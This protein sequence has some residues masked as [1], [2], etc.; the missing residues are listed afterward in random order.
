M[1][2]AVHLTIAAVP[3]TLNLP[4][5]SQAKRIL[6]CFNT[7]LAEFELTLDGQ[8]ITGKN[9][10]RLLISMGVQGTITDK[11]FFPFM[12]YSSRQISLPYTRTYSFYNCSATGIEI[13]LL[14]LMSLHKGR[15]CMIYSSYSRMESKFC[16]KWY[17]SNKY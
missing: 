8:T 2:T 14:K 16:P 12:G 13:R 10:P 17:M 7:P 5:I 4:Q 15:R 3:L 9:Y 11:G 6:A 1:E